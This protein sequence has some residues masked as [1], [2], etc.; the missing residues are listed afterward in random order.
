MRRAVWVCVCV[1][2][3][4][5]LLDAN[6]DRR[7][8]R[9]TW[10][11]RVPSRALVGAPAA[12]AVVRAQP[13]PAGRPRDPGA[14]R[15]VLPSRSWW[16][17]QPWPIPQNNRVH[18]ARSWNACTRTGHAA[19]LAAGG[20][21]VSFRDRQG[22]NLNRRPCPPNLKLFRRPGLSLI[23]PSFCVK[24]KRAQDF[25]PSAAPTTTRMFA[26]VCL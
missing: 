2:V 8:C 11:R 24:K 15:V 4:S 20:A 21:P 18:P 19:R 22:H 16:P 6:W 13:R 14:I 23:S 26:L 25:T 12:C 3:S 1:R 9:G 7:P 10:R 17:D 5:R